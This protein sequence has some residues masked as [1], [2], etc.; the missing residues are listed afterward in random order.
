M[1]GDTQVFFYICPQNAIRERS[2]SMLPRSISPRSE[3]VLQ[4]VSLSFLFFHIDYFYF[5]FF[6]FWGRYCFYLFFYVISSLL[7]LF[8]I[9]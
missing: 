7:F 6:I 2:L 1:I 3:S 4:A 8:I 5:L 9:F